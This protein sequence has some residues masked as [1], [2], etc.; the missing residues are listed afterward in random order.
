M[1]R[2]AKSELDMEYKENLSKILKNRSHHPII[3]SLMISEFVE[4]AQKLKK[5][6]TSR[7][8]PCIPPSS[9]VASD[10]KERDRS[11]KLSFRKAVVPNYERTNSLIGY[12]DD[13]KRL[14]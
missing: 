2:E 13:H 14:F 7:M 9:N 6:H 3:L 1:Q 11:R 12:T 10:T 4:K 8:F 5:T